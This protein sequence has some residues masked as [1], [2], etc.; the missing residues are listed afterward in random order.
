MSISWRTAT[1]LTA[2]TSTALTW[3]L[4]T[5]HTVGDLLVAI[6]GGK[7]YTS[8]SGSPTDYVSAGSVASGARANSNGSGSTRAQVFTKTHDG[9]ESNPTATLTASPSPSMVAMLAAS[10]TEPGAWLIASTTGADTTLTGTAI[11]ATGADSLT[12]RAGE[13]VMIVSVGNDNLETESGAALAIGAATFTITEVLAANATST[14]NDGSMAVYDCLVTAGGTGEPVFT[15]TSGRSGNS[16]RAVVFLQLW[17]PFNAA[18]ATEPIGLTDSLTITFSKVLNDAVGMDDEAYRSLFADVDTDAIGA[19]DSLFVLTEIFDL[20]TETGLGVTDSRAVSRS[21]ALTNDTGLIS[22]D[23][24][25]SFASGPLIEDDVDSTDEL[26]LDLDLVLVDDVEVSDQISTGRNLTDD[27][28]VG[29]TVAVHLF[30]EILDDTG[31]IALQP[32]RGGSLTLEHLIEDR[33]RLRDSLHVE[34]GLYQSEGAIGI[35]DDEI[36]PVETGPAS[37]S[38]LIEDDIYVRDA[39]TTRSVEEV[40]DTDPVDATDSVEPHQYLSLSDDVDVT[41]SLAKDRNVSKTDL[42]TTETDEIIVYKPSGVTIQR[43]LPVEDIGVTDVDQPTYVHYIPSDVS[44]E[45]EDYV[46]IVSQPLE[47]DWTGFFLRGVDDR[48]DVVDS[49]VRDYDKPVTDAV[50]VIDSVAASRNVALSDDE[51]VTDQVNT[52]SRGK[53]DAVGIREDV[54]SRLTKYGFTRVPINDEMDVT[55]EISIVMNRV[56]TVE[57]MLDL[58][59]LSTLRSPNLKIV[60]TDIVGTSEPTGYPDAFGW[61]PVWSM[62]TPTIMEAPIGGH[63]LFH[64]YQMERGISLLITG[65]TVTEKRFPTVDELEAAD[66]Y[67]LGG[68]IASVD[69]VEAE[70]LT[71]AGYGDYLTMTQERLITVG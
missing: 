42:T 51:D 26:V 13:R 48:V 6:Y 31:L 40:L 61:R 41:D 27:I 54:E 23:P 68:H 32:T 19:T 4:P 66:R 45:I 20:A 25:P 69:A 11:S 64:Y 56:R 15:A 39:G 59:D 10:K 63:R 9:T 37:L 46:Q 70:F 49:T 8:T 71:D 29:S 17:E 34:K 62:A 12:V 24:I 43:T 65:T 58:I 7:P 67:Y 50:G 5:G 60:V 35:A 52:M 28:S 16:E 22:L 57:D 21:V 3:T 30:V 1:G 53:T 55:D 44:R 38:E 2:G 14:G 18:P 47:A 33:L 36:I